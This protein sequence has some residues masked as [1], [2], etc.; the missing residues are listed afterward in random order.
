MGDG[1]EA[2]WR[3]PEAEQSKEGGERWHCSACPPRWKVGARRW[4]GLGCFAGP[5]LEERESQCRLL[6]RDGIQ[7]VGQE[8]APVIV[9]RTDEGGERD[10][11]SSVQRVL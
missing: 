6:R 5:P 1:D 4:Q 2:Q 10:S 8:N 9:G 3:R 11:G 7:H